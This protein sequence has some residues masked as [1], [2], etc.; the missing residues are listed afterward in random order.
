MTSNDIKNICA[1]FDLYPSKSKGQNFLIDDNIVKKIITAADLLP[2][3]KILEIGPGLGVLTSELLKVSGEVWAA[4]LDKKIIEFLKVN[5]FRDLETGKL[6]LIEGDALKINFRELGLTD[7][8]FK[9]V[10]NLP[11][12]LTSK[13]FRQFLE[14]GPKSTE[15]IVMIQK[16]VAL[17]LMARQG[18]MNLLALSAQFFSEPK[19]LFTVPR[20]CFWPEPEVESAVV[21]LKLKKK[22]PSVDIKQLFRIARIGFSAKRKQLHNNLSGGLKIK[23]VEVKRI[24]AELGLRED[25]RAQDL[26]VEDW[27]KL[28]K[29]FG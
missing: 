13:F 9:I 3:D 15:I 7:W 24:L 25:V 22:L 12:C 23:S 16:E 6:K 28:T 29:R 17:R 2:T 1:K 5:Y 11:Y 26:R 10:A 8:S 21:Q 27:I 20:S 18:E 14:F 19:M 4:E